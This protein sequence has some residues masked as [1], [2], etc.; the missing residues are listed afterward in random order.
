MRRAAAPAPARAQPRA[1]DGARAVRGQATVKRPVAPARGGRPFAFW[2]GRPA[3]GH[4]DPGGREFLDPAPAQGPEARPG[5]GD[6]LEGNRGRNGSTVHVVTLPLSLVAA[7][8]GLWNGGQI[9]KLTGQVETLRELL[10]THVTTPGA[11]SN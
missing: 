10:A 1:P 9:A 4:P 5:N 11:H 3:L 7:L 2:G 6:R 8:A